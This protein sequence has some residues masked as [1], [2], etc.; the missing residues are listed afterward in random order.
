MAE[1]VAQIIYVFGELTKMEVAINTAISKSK[2]P[3]NEIRLM[4]QSTNKYQVE[5]TPLFQY[6]RQLFTEIGLG[7]P[8]CIS[9][10]P[11]KITISIKN[12]KVPRLFSNVHGKTC[13]VTAD[14]IKMFFEKD[15]EIISEVTE[16]KCVNAGDEYCEFEV[17][18]N[19]VEVLKYIVNEI[20][21]EVMKN[22]KNGEIA[23]LPAELKTLERYG[24]VKAQELT[25]LGEKYL[26]L[27]VY[28]E[29][30]EISR[31]WKRLSEISEVTASANS[32]AEAFSRSIEHDVEEVDEK[33]LINVVDEVEN[34]RSFAELVAKVMKKEVKNDE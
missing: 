19:P 14:A 16:T 22:L 30:N 21:I 1:G 5:R 9:I 20:D 17:N 31:P 33:E 12:S 18:M 6:M 13:Y 29:N 11:Y 26:E 25:V 10:E 28:S 3:T 2:I 23:E 32:F 34:S 4:L 24:L 8:G 7:E 15:M 27:G